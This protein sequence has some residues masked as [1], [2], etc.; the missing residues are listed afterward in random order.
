MICGFAGFIGSHFTRECLKQG[1][2]VEGI[3]VMTYASE[4]KH[5]REFNL[6]PNFSFKYRD[7]NH[8]ESLYGCD[9]IVNFAAES[10]VELSIQNSKQFLHSNINGVHNLLELIKGTEIPLIQISSDEVYGD[11]LVGSHKETDNLNPSNPYAASKAGG[12]LLILSYARTY[13]IKYNIIHLT[14]NFGLNQNFE[15]LI[16]KTIKFLKEGKK[17]PLHNN[18]T[19]LRNWL[20][21]SDSVGAILTILE[22]GELNEIYNVNGNCELN[23]L[24]TVSLIIFK[25]LQEKIFDSTNYLD[26]SC[27]REGQDWRYSLDDSKLKALGWNPKADF[28]EKLD[29]IINSYK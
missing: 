6:H 25:F 15:K 16:P 21:V 23:N 20:H 22:K 10:S 11:I 12:D 5:V 17:I 1:Y 8:L 2:A 14:N 3:D 24:S 19:P 18:G 7:I 28:E 13:G 27:S 26:F 9:L 29:E 4:E